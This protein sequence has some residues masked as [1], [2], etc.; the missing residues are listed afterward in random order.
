MSQRSPLVSDQR[1]YKKDKLWRHERR[2][3]QIHGAHSFSRHLR[4]DETHGGKFLNNVIIY[5]Y[6]HNNGTSSARTE[7]IAFNINFQ[8]LSTLTLKVEGIHRTALE[9]G[10]IMGN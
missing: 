5:I 2:K 9:Q 4:R 1:V 7:I 10:W 8:Y 6:D 3:A